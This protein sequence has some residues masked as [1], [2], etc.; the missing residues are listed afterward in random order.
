MALLVIVQDLLKT[1]DSDCFKD[2]IKMA[3]RRARVKMV[4]NFG[5]G[6]RGR[7][8][9]GKI[10]EVGADKTDCNDNKKLIVDTEK[11]N[12]VKT[13]LVDNVG[14]IGDVKND[15]KDGTLTRSRSRSNEKDPGKV[16]DDEKEQKDET[17]T[18]SRSRS[19]EKKDK[20]KENVEPPKSPIDETTNLIKP[21]TEI[22]VTKPPVEIM[23]T[24]PLKDLKINPPI[25]CQDNLINTTEIQKPTTEIPIKEAVKVETNIK[26]SPTKITNSLKESSSDLKHPLVRPPLPSRLKQKFKPNLGTSDSRVRRARKLSGGDRRPR[27]LSNSES[28]PRRPRTTSTGSASG[29]EEE[30]EEEETAATVKTPQVPPPIVERDVVEAN[31]MPDTPLLVVNRRTSQEASCKS[32]KEEVALPKIEG[33]TRKL[34]GPKPPDKSAN[35][36]LRRKQDHKR[37]FQC[38]IPERGRMTMFDLI[39]YN[40]EHGKR[41]STEELEANADDIVENEDAVEVVNNVPEEP[42]EVPNIQ[43]EPVANDTPAEEEDNAMP[44]PQVKVG[45]NGEIILD[46]ASTL[47][48][49]TQAKQAKHDLQNSPV[50]FENANRATN[51]GTWSKKRKHSD[52]SNKETLKFYRALSVVGSDF[53][54]MA[55]L[56]S[57]KTR[58]E[59]KLKFKK[60]EKINGA[61][62]DRCLS[63]QGQYTDL[64][65]FDEDSEDDDEPPIVQKRSRQKSKPKKLRTGTR[66]V[67]KN[68]GYYSSSDAEDDNDSPPKSSRF[69]H[70]PPAGISQRPTPQSATRPHTISVVR[71]NNDVGGDHSPHRSSSPLLQNLLSRPQ[72]QPE[73]SVNSAPQFPPGLLAANPGLSGVKPGSLVVVASPSKTDPSSQLLHVYMVSPKNRIGSPSKA[74][75]E[76]INTNSGLVR[77]RPNMSPRQGSRSPSPLSRPPPPSTLPTPPSRKRT[78]SESS[79]TSTSPTR[80]RTLSETALEGL[81]AADADLPVAKKSKPPDGTSSM[82]T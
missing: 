56:F 10:A 52:W 27:T 81:D 1:K 39:Y 41:M 18:R 6:S 26:E 77:S 28:S 16:V 74:L 49:T 32:R 20:T 72:N 4:P 63:Q 5:S 62:I 47:V 44:V 60:E 31:G 40:P 35:A 14:K 3:T 50:V 9:P 12:E 75:D 25:I 67:T 79:A 51:Y 19:N 54:M 73:G 2:Q 24:N 7:S 29:P 82:E 34:T 64:Q 8:R 66:R 76:V 80:K 65:E 61:M 43:E 57:T 22:N 36:L 17:T 53:S 68:R 21:P 59:L 69:S 78:L 13:N 45:P 58:Q 71:A 70:K 37:K 15:D 48:E 38:G 55:S 11:L 46:E 42:A 33:R 23:Q 30:E